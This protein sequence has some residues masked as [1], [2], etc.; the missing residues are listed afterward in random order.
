MKLVLNC[1]TFSTP[2][3]HTFRCQFFQY[4]QY[5]SFL[6]LVSESKQS[7]GRIT[8]PLDC[9]VASLLA[10]TVT[11]PLV[12]DSRGPE[13]LL[14]F[15]SAGAIAQQTVSRDAES[16]AQVENSGWLNIVFARRPAEVT[17][18][19]IS[20]AHDIPKERSRAVFLRGTPA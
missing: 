2:T 14:C 6:F 11:A 16:L 9:L 5:D 1:A 19:V 15:E 17:S 10:M 3:R 7:R 20:S 4:D 13:A 8:R 12:I 18:S